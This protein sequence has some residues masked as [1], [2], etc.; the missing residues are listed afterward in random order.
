V[1]LGNSTKF[2]FSLTWNVSR[3]IRV[4]LYLRANQQHKHTV[5]VLHKH[6]S[7]RN[8]LDVFILTGCRQKC[9]DGSWKPTDN[10]ISEFQRQQS[11][12]LPS[13][14][15]NSLH[16]HCHHQNCHSLLL[17]GTIPPCPLLTAF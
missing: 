6:C 15:L 17:A 9:N 2:V 5:D 11:T 12:D 14:G 4:S 3:L 7:L 13:G 8:T 1:L 16:Q 10:V